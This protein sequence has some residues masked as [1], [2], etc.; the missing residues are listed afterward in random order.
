MDGDTICKLDLL[1]LRKIIIRTAL[2]VKKNGYIFRDIVDMHYRAYIAVKNPFALFIG[3]AVDL[4]CPN[5]IIIILILHDPVALAEQ[6]IA[7]AAFRFI[8]IG[9]IQ[10]I[11]K[12]AVQI[13]DAELVILHRSEYLYITAVTLT[14]IVITEIEHRAERDIRAAAFI[15]SEIGLGRSEYRHFSVIDE[16]GVGYN[17]ASA[18]L[19]I[20]PVKLDNG[21]GLRMH[22]IAEHIPRSDRWKLIDIT[23][24]D[25][26]CPFRY[27][28]KER[29]EQRNI[30]H[31]HLINYYHVR[32]ERVITVA[33]EFI[34]G[35][36]VFKQPVEGLCFP[37]RCIGHALC[38]SARGCGK[39]DL[40]P[41]CFHNIYYKAEYRGLA[42]AGAAGHDDDAVGTAPLYRFGLE[43]REP[44]LELCFELF[45]CIINIE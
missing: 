10:H 14:C 39:G 25:E 19:T 38:S 31:G 35:K 17:H 44:E 33:V 3:L 40:E 18:C 37:A 30:H 12:P 27:R 21:H 13:V 8:I 32:I 23:D 9:R 2:I 28:A 29:I 42:G 16:M 43:R 22:Y 4:A 20:D 36:A 6:G 11:L 45:D 24:H 26:P 34:I 15:E 1:K 7:E 5:Y 41:H